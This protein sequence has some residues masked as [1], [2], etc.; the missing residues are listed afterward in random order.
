MLS[1]AAIEHASLE[2]VNIFFDTATYDEI[3]KDVRVK[4]NSVGSV[5]N[6]IS[7]GK[8]WHVKISTS[9]WYP[10]CFDLILFVHPPRWQLRPSWDWLEAPWASSLVS[11]YSV[12]LRSS[13]TL[14][15]LFFWRKLT[16]LSAAIYIIK[17]EVY[18]IPLR[19]FISLKV[20]NITNKRSNHQKRNT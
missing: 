14:S 5:L 6:A 7:L 15:G 18:E 13:T 10:T 3:E 1:A 11:R 17:L 12:G 2:E 4:Q 16:S 8:C 9:W 19:F 20:S